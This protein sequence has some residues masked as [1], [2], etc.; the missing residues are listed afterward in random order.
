M[1]AN[2]NA[3][4]QPT[5]ELGISGIIHNVFQS[6]YTIKQ[7]FK[8]NC[9]QKINYFPREGK[10]H[11]DIVCLFVE[12]FPYRLFNNAWVAGYCFDFWRGLIMLCYV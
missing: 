7:I 1:A 9:W 4:T 8:K 2:E 11:E 3:L 5:F 12:P 10:F 6:D